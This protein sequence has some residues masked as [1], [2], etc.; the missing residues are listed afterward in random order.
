MHN[1]IVLTIELVHKYVV[2]WF[3]MD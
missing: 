2:L 3:I 1:N